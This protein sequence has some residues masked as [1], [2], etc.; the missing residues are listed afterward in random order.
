[1]GKWRYSSIF[2]ISA[3]RGGERSA[4]CTC[5]FNLGGEVRIEMLDLIACLHDVEKTEIPAPA[6]NQN[7]AV[8]PVAD[9]YT[10]W[11]IP[12]YHLIRNF[13]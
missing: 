13:D 8:Q 4:S 2:L 3:L 11:G 7:P 10:D 9:H 5:H 6:G 12:A 1:M